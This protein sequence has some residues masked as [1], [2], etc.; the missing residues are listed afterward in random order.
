LPI[1]D[2]RLVSLP[3]NPLAASSEDQDDE[4]EDEQGELA[5]EPGQQTDRGRN[6]RGSSDRQLRITKAAEQDDRASH[7]EG[8]GL[9][10]NQECVRE[11]G[12]REYENQDDDRRVTR[13]DAPER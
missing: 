13:S 2:E 7:C 1:C 8:S 11:D 12:R 9:R 5:V 4:P 10:K 3:G 6:N